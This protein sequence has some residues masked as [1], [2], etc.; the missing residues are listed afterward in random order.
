MRSEYDYSNARP[1]PCARKIKKQVTINV[2]ADSVDY[3][4]V[5]AKAI[6]LPYQTLIN[7]YLSDCVEHKKQL[8]VSWSAPDHRQD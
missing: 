2:D 6:G 4:K 3:F 1:N 8:R 5:Q 7:L